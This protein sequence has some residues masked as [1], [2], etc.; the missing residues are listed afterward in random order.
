MGKLSRVFTKTKYVANEKKP[1]LE[2]A[3]GIVGV[4]VGAFFLRKAAK[5]EDAIIMKHRA[6]LEQIKIEDKSE[7]DEE[8]TAKK[9]AEAEIE[10]EKAKGAAITKTYGETGIALIKNYTL[11]V[12]CMGLGLGLIVCSHKTLKGRYTAAVLTAESLRKAWSA[13]R[14][15][16]KE[17]VGE[18]KEKE[19]YTG[20]TVVDVA[21]VDEKTHEKTTEVGFVQKKDDINEYGPFAVQIGKE[22]RTWERSP[23]YMRDRLE[24]WECYFTRKLNKNGLLTAYEV[25]SEMD[26]LKFVKPE[27]IPALQRWGWVKKDGIGTGVV[28]F[29]LANAFKNCEREELNGMEYYPIIDLNCDGDICEINA[30]YDLK[31]FGWAR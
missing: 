31:L 1:E 15:R 6:K 7:T 27:I 10:E 3:A 20:G 25:Y 12:A 28:S 26:C 18:E 5:N 4:V 21:V 24:D 16:V 17:A 13:Y 19:I 8:V 2:L 29:N 22:S 9:D 23:R 14:G 11:P 30:K